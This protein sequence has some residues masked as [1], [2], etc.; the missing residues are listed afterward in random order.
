MDAN[1]EGRVLGAAFYGGGWHRA[2]EIHHIPIR[3][4]S[5][6]FALIRGKSG[7]GHEWTRMKKGEC[8]GTAF[9]GG[10]WHRAED[11]RHIPIRVH[12]R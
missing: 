10:G 6:S 3:V 9:Y 4:Y 5:R 11:I 7:N 2:E 8:W 1:E 12:S